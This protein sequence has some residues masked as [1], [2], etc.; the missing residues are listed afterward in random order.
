MKPLSHNYKSTT[1]NN[2][3]EVDPKPHKLKK[4]SVTKAHPLLRTQYMLYNDIYS[5]N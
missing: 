5:I 2:K 1:Q 3:E 4:D